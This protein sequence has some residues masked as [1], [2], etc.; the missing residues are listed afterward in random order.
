MA[1]VLPYA[2]KYLFL[3][4]NHCKR[5]NVFSDLPKITRIFCT[6]LRCKLIVGAHQT[7]SRK[8]FQ[9]MFLVLLC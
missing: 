7:H 1:S 2:Q 6:L 3:I 9:E 8:F 5:L 4:D